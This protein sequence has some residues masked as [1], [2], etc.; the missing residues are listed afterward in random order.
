M[1]DNK[2]AQGIVFAAGSYLLW[3]ILPIYW[4]LLQ[5]VS[6]LQLLAHRV[7]WSLLFLLI[8]M[9]VAGRLP[10]FLNE[11]K[12]IFRKPQ[13][14][15]SI[16]VAAIMLNINWGLY[17]WAVNDNRIIQTSLGY[18]ISPLISV[19][20]GM[21]FLRE[22]LSFW[23]WVA[24]GLAIIGV[25]GLTL[26]A[27]AFP[28]VSLTLAVTFGLYGLFKKLNRVGAISGL[29][30]ETLFTSIFALS[31][32]VYID[33][34]GQGAFHLSLSPTTLLL[35]GAGVVSA[36]PLILFGAGARRL[37]LYAVGFLQYI[38]PTIALIL[39]V[40]VYHEPFSR[41]HLLSFLVIWIGLLIFSLANTTSL[42]G[43]NKVEY[44]G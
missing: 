11:V 19:L 43:K 28:W 40:L 26:E 25:I 41:A 6:S 33:H 23:Q 2:K 14:V 7:V 17:I 27:G 13:A 30:L 18:Y 39:G 29:T 31:Y 44:S 24:F 8:L 4:K 22:R 36:T 35:L 32:L 34:I 16:V 9:L 1:L 3:G 10:A 12:T 21:F 42:P 20:L 37:P 15:L 38:S 5:E